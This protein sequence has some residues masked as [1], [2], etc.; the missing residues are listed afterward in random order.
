MS[1]AAHYVNKNSFDFN[2]GI[3]TLTLNVMVIMFLAHFI[4]LNSYN[5]SH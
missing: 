5:I 4:Y 1:M 3:I 2:Y